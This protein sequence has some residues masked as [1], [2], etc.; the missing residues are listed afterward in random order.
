MAYLSVD[1]SCGKNPAFTASSAEYARASSRSLDTL[2]I[3]R[4]ILYFCFEVH[5]PSRLMIRTRNLVRTDTAN[6]G[7]WTNPPRS[8]S[9]RLHA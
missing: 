3:N 1:S 9:P 2:E 4:A 8:A 6:R 5:V 7:I